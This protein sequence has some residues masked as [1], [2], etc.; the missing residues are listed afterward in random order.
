[1]HSLF[2][3]YRVDKYCFQCFI[4]RI[5]WLKTDVGSGKPLLEK[6]LATIAKPIDETHVGLA[7]ELIE[8]RDSSRLVRKDVIDQLEKIQI[9][10]N[11]L[12]KKALLIKQDLE[13]V[14]VLPFFGP[15]LGLF[16]RRGIYWII[17]LEDSIVDVN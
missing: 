7:R 8:F 9:R 2:D 6:A 12:E 16:H 13:V 1:M 4:R 10:Q 5:N 3:S 15:E 11:E 14:L 17:T